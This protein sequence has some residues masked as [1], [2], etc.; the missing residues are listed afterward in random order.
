MLKILCKGYTRRQKAFVKAVKDGGIGLSAMYGNI[1]TGLSQPEEL[2]H[3]TE[4]AQ[5][6]EKE[7]GFK[8]DSAMMSDVPGFAWSLV[9][10][11]T[12][13]GVKYFSSGP[14]YL[15]KPILTG[16]R[17]GNF[18][19]NWGQTCMVAVSIRKRKILF[20]TAGRGYSSWHGIHP[21]AVFRTGQKKLQNTSMILP[22]PITHMIL[23]NGATILYR[24]TDLSTLQYQSL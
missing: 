22:E 18:V 13:S 23:Y 4:Y 2:F 10:A 20:W 11:F 16:D 7:Y 14:N 6:L 24:T 15:G 9:P 19:K 17:V 8:I 5:K 1:L 3:Y 12:T 21:G